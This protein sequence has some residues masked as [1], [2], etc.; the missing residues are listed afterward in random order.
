MKTVIGWLLRCRLVHAGILCATVAAIAVSVAWSGNPEARVNLGGVWVG[1][2]MGIQWISTHA[3]LDADGKTAV[4]TLQWAAL[5]GDFLAL[6]ASLG[7]DRISQVS[8]NF[9]LIN[10]DTAKY[11]L[12]WYGI[13]SGSGTATPPVGDEVKTINI[14]EGTWRCTGPNTGESTETYSIYLAVPGH[15]L[16]PAPGAQPVYSTTFPPHP[17]YRISP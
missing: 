5:N 4:A 8:G 14:L 11:V 6:A 1:E 10:K 17:Q 13:K 12:I 3:P 7:V 9:R 2:L 15:T 16:L